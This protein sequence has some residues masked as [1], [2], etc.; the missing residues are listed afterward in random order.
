MYPLHVIMCKY[1]NVFALYGRNIKIAFP[2]FIF[3]GAVY[4]ILYSVLI[5]LLRIKQHENCCTYTMKTIQTKTFVLYVWLLLHFVGLTR[6]LD[7][8]ANY[9]WQIKVT[10]ESRKLKLDLGLCMNHFL[11]HLKMKHNYNYEQLLTHFFLH[12]NIHIFSIKTCNGRCHPYVDIL[13]RLWNWASVETITR[14]TCSID[15][16]VS[17]PMSEQQLPTS[18]VFSFQWVLRLLFDAQNE[19]SGSERVKNCWYYNDMGKTSF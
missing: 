6:H 18:V 9:T 4:A 2:Y 1:R 19:A 7:G 12:L 10:L 16:V 15:F 17:T 11:P 8:V 14:L 5:G 13:K 3:Q